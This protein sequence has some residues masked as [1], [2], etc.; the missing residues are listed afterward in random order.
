MTSCTVFTGLREENVNKVLVSTLYRLFFA[1]RELK[2]QRR[3]HRER[4]KSNRFKL[5]KQNFARGRFFV[6]YLPLLH[7][8]DVKLPYFTFSG[9]RETQDNDCF[10]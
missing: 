1:I 8:H 3:R 9:G 7:G 5:A 10:L 4:I 6:I 2:H